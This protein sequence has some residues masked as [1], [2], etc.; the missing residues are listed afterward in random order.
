LLGNLPIRATVLYLTEGPTENWAAVFTSN[1]VRTD[2]LS[3]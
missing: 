2:K 3:R 1:K